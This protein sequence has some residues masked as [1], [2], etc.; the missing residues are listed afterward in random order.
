MIMWGFA[1]LLSASASGPA[2]L[3]EQMVRNSTAERSPGAHDRR[4]VRRVATDGGSHLVRDGEG[5]RLSAVAALPRQTRKTSAAWVV[6]VAWVA[7][8][9]IST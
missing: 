4:I 1:D 2:V 7:D 6:W 5:P 3:V 9:I 8:G